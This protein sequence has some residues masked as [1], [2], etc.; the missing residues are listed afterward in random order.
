MF[1]LAISD[2][3]THCRPAGFRYVFVLQIKHFKKKSYSK[4]SHAHIVHA[5]Q[6]VDV[7][8]LHVHVLRAQI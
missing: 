3:F 6:S 4:V 7:T 5:R 2:V 1:F 8:N